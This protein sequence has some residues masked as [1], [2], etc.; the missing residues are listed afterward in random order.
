MHYGGSHRE[1]M[2]RLVQTYIEAGQPWPAETKQMATWAIE[3]GLWQAHR[4]ALVVQ[5]AE[6]LSRAMREEYHTDPQ[7]RRV[8]TKHAARMRVNGQQTT[9][10]GDIRTADRKHMEV[11]FANRRAQIVGD[12]RQLKNDVDSFN[13]NAN[14]G[15]PI[16]TVF[17]FTDDLAESET[18]EPFDEAA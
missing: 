17:D 15:V 6:E 5:C 11:A 3:Q 7:G 16:Q 9:L 13:Q 12:C 14:D 10:W 2:Q 4:D 18:A 8:R 1:Q